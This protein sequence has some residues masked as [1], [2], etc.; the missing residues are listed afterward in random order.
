M[1]L[2]EI[3]KKLE[4]AYNTEDWDIIEDVISSLDTIITIGDDAGDWDDFEDDDNY[5]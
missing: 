4:E 1:N 2:N 3:K 5:L